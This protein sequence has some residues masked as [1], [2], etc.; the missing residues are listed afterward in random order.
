MPSKD[1]RAASR[2]A[3]L[4]QKRRRAKDPAYTFDAGPTASQ[5]TSQSP[6]PETQPEQRLTPKSAPVV[7]P[8]SQPA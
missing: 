1:H 5:K 3:K 4:R 6:I 7:P 8:A 2:Q